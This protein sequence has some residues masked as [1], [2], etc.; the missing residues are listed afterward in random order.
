VG[1]DIHADVQQRA[2]GNARAA[3][4]EKQQQGQVEGQG[5]GP[6]VGIAPAAFAPGQRE[7]IRQDADQRRQQELRAAA[8]A[9]PVGQPG[10]GDCVERYVHID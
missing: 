7:D 8:F 9:Q 6:T 5:M 10:G 4:Q 3:P 1:E 2:P